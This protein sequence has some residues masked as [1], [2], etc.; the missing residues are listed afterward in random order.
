MG[1]VKEVNQI[2]VVHN[3]QAF[4]FNEVVHIFEETAPGIPGKKTKFMKAWFKGVDNTKADE[5]RFICRPVVG[6]SG[7]PFPRYSS[8]AIFK[9]KVQRKRNPFPHPDPTPNLLLNLQVL[10]FGVG[11][12]EEQGR[13]NRWERLKPASKER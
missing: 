13:R 12:L 7:G 4:R 6:H 8:G 1:D 3:G 11:V 9:V 5:E 10:V 2:V